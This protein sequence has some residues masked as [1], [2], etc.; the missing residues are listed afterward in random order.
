MTLLSQS[1]A[2]VLLTGVLEPVGDRVWFG[3]KGSQRMKRWEFK[4]SITCSSPKAF[5]WGC[6]IGFLSAGR[7]RVH[8]GTPP[9]HHHH[10]CCSRL[11]KAVCGR[12]GCST[13]ALGLPLPSC[14]AGAC[15]ALLD[16]GPELR[17][18]AQP[19]HTRNSGLKGLV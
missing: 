14:I 15:A 19:F 5:D 13:S 17:C 3:R 6:F 7:G 1:P 9:P 8:A 10:V 18:Q 2:S 16:R 11:Q 12:C 4:L